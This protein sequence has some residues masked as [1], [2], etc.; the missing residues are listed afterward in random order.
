MADE[1]KEKELPNSFA[2]SGPISDR[3]RKKFDDDDPGWGGDRSDTGNNDPNINR[4][5]R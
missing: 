4:M 1:K 5:R 3:L 2:A